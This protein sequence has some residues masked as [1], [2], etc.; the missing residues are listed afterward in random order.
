MSDY[1]VHIRAR[2]FENHRSLCNQTD[3]PLLTVLTYESALSKTAFTFCPDCLEII[4]ANP[5]IRL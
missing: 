2:P 3:V 4:K 1:L 5:Y